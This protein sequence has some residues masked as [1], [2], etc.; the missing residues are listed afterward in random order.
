MYQRVL[1]VLCRYLYS[2][3]R[4][5]GKTR[6]VLCLYRGPAAHVTA[7]S[8]CAAVRPARSVALIRVPALRGWFGGLSGSGRAGSGQFGSG[9]GG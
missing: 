9:A 1:K 8:A 3:E 6:R 4:Y 5:G 2:F 7:G